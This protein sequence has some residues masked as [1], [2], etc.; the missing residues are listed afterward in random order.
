MTEKKFEF[1][2]EN[3]KLFANLINARIEKILK[4]PSNLL[5][6]SNFG[7]SSKVSILARNTTC[8]NNLMTKKIL[9]FGR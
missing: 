5:Q 8:G 7:T 9:I 6:V 1:L 2:D 4:I 3:D